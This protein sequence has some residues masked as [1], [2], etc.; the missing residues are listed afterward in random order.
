MSEKGMKWPPIPGDFEVGDPSR[1]VAVCTLGKK[2]EVPADYAIIGTCK[3]ENIGIERVIV[4]LVSN[5]SIRFLI[6]AGPEVPGHLTGSSMKCLYNNGIEPDTRRII[7]APG[8]I[9]YIENIPIEAV[10]RFR[11]QVTFIDMMNI[12]RPDAIAEQVRELNKKSPDAYPKEAIWIDFTVAARPTV[13]VGLG[14][15]VSLL[16]EYRV[17][18]DPSS[19]LVAPKDEGAVISVHPSQVVVEIQDRETGT[20]IIGKEL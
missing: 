14:V 16:P 5:P 3:T 15:S 10:E 11:E 9:P 8:A 4:N 18:L 19:S 6:L 7:E 12:S 13:A 17:A 20:I 2:V 1:C